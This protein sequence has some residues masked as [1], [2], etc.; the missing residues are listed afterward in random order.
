[1][2]ER[3]PASIFTSP[4][5]LARKDQMI[6]NLIE[7]QR[8]LGNQNESLA[9]RIDELQFQNS[10]LKEMLNACN[11]EA[12]ASLRNSA[13]L[14]AGTPDVAMNARLEG[15]QRLNVPQGDNSVSGYGSLVDDLEKAHEPAVNMESTGQAVEAFH[16]WSGYEDKRLA[17]ESST[18]SPDLGMVTLTHSSSS[19]ESSRMH[20]PPRDSDIESVRRKLCHCFTN[21]L[22]FL[23][24]FNQY[25]I[26]SVTVFSLSNILRRCL[27]NTSYFLSLFNQYSIL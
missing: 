27:I 6:Q 1:M 12:Q 13:A 23:S 17:S 14:P 24:L 11:M 9:H 20:T 10:Q 22:Y 3:R 15:K 16:R 26:F 2:Y 7:S 8:L 25:V 4:D 18:T 21:T 5:E 19:G